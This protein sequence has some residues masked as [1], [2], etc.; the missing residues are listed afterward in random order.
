MYT[1]NDDNIEIP[2]INLNCSPKE[3]AEKAQKFDACVKHITDEELIIGIR[4]QD[5][6]GYIDENG[7]P[8][9]LR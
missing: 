4:N 6:P 9:V 2:K 7:K 3:M 5:I 1:Y 8:H